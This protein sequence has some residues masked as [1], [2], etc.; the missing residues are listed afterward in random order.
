MEYKD[1]EI[2]TAEDYKN[3]EILYL[4]TQVEESK[5]STKRGVYAYGAT[6]DPNAVIPTWGYKLLDHLP[7]PPQDMI[8]R[9]LAAPNPEWSGLFSG[10]NGR[11]IGKDTDEL[12]W[13]GRTFRAAHQA[14]VSFSQLVNPGM[15][16][17]DLPT[18]DEF[19]VWVKENLTDNFLNTGLFFAKGTA[20][21]PTVGAHDD[22][23]RDLVL[24]YCFRKGGPDTTLYYWQE[25]GEPLIR[26]RG[27]RRFDNSKLNVVDAYRSTD[28]ELKRCWCLVNTRILHGID[29]MIETRTNF[30]VSFINSVP[31]EILYK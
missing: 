29:H 9:A 4:D 28:E 5:K 21:Q 26:D 15:A 13:D 16:K 6:T 17:E 18:E 8:D 20:E 3:T 12:S 2:V 24:I 7:I 25:H 10:I 22:L 30:Q 19:S 11:V 27:V 14:R 31:D 1:T 23:T